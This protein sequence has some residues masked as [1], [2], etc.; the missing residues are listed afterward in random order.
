[1]TPTPNLFRAFATLLLIV[2]LGCNHSAEKTLQSSNP[3]FEIQ[4]IGKAD[5]CII[6]RFWDGGNVHYFVRC[7][8]ASD[9]STTDLRNCGKNCWH[10]EEIQTVSV[11]LK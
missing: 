3:G 11:G 10:L 4:I 9:V 5:G 6:Y 7:Q 1:M 2:L 8:G